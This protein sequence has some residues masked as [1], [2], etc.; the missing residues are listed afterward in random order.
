MRVINYSLHG[1]ARVV[2]KD[3]NNNKQ[4]TNGHKKYPLM[5]GDLTI[6]YMK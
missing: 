3:I 6:E 4:M 2:Q 1:L 5:T